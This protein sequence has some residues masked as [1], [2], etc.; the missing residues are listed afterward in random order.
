MVG[1]ESDSTEK[2]RGFKKVQ[3]HTKIYTKK[4]MSKK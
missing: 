4:N 3:N 1:F 2:S